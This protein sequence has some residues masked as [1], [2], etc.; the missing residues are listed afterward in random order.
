MMDLHHGGSVGSLRVMV[1]QPWPRVPLGV[2]AVRLPAHP[3][4]IWLSRWLPIDPFVEIA[5]PRWRD[6]DMLVDRDRGVV[7]CSAKQLAAIEQEI[8]SR[9]GDG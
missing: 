1:V 8:S 4:I 6:A 2:E 3:I 7:F 5:V 9:G